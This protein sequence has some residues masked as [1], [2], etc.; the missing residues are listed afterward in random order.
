MEELIQTNSQLHDQTDELKRRFKDFVDPQVHQ[1]LQ[2]DFKGL[3]EQ[4]RVLDREK[5]QLVKMFDT[6]SKERDNAQEEFAR[7]KQEKQLMSVELA[8]MT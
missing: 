2:Q 6:L 4:V 8:K 5:Q 3:D 7:A 1:K